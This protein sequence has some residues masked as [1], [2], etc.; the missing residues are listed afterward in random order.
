[1]AALPAADLVRVNKIP[2]RIGRNRNPLVGSA[3]LWRKGTRSWSVEIPNSWSE[4]ES[5]VLSSK[6]RRAFRSRLKN[7]EAMG[8]VA[9]VFANDDSSATRI[10]DALC[11]HRE[12]RFAKLGRSNILRSAPYREFYR[13]IVWRSIPS[14]PAFLSALTVDSQVVATMLG[15]QWRD[16]YLALIPTMV[17]GD[18]QKHGIGKLMNWFQMKEMHARGCRHFDFTIG[19]ESYKRDYGAQPSEL[20]EMVL[21]LKLYSRPLAWAFR[22]RAGLGRWRE[23]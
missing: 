5:A 15:L 9:Y 19:N 22:M 14:G 18:L 17:E 2:E 3:G 7:L 16:C 21:P 13:Q 8:S 20:Y 10:F 1:M 4:Y 6:I 12:A 23:A 11:A